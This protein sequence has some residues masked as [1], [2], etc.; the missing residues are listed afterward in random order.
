MF[1]RLKGFEDAL[2]GIALKPGERFPLRLVLQLRRDA[3]PMRE[4]LVFDV[5]QRSGKG[6]VVGDGV[7]AKASVAPISIQA[8][9]ADTVKNDYIRPGQPFRSRA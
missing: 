2:D 1:V 9:S 8:G 7:V 5:V 4:P 6:E 3:K